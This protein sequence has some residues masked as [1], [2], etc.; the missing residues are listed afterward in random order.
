ML[1]LGLGHSAVELLLGGKQKRKRLGVVASVIAGVAVPVFVALGLAVEV[2]LAVTVLARVVVGRIG[3]AFA[4]GREHPVGFAV[5]AVLAVL[6]VLAA[7]AAM[8]VSAVA[9]LE[10]EGLA[11]AAVAELAVVVGAVAAARALAFQVF[12]C[13]RSFRP[14]TVADTRVLVVALLADIVAVAMEVAA[15]V[16]A[17][18]VDVGALL[19]FS[20]TSVCLFAHLE[21]VVLVVPVVVY[22]G[23]QKRG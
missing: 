15:R 6:P 22:A 11:T 7:P 8:A 18:F 21:V 10:H 23:V 9:A 3:E 16:V 12:R 14:S 17:A 4:V 1:E 19:D 2:G 5:L 13:T 20:H